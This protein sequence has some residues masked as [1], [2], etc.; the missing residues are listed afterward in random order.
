MS[1]EVNTTLQNRIAVVTGAG[2]GIGHAIAQALAARGA[3]LCLVG[4]DRAKLDATRD[5]LPQAPAA[6]VHVCD[7][8]EP[9]DISALASAIARAHARVD[10]LVHCAATI[11]MGPIESAP[12]ADFDRQF[13][14]NLRAP[15]LLTQLLL[16]LVK[17]ASGQIAFINSSVAL[18]GKEGVGAYCATKHGLKGLADT[19]R[20]EVN[21]H[22]IR[23]LSVYAGNTD[24]PMQREIHKHIGK[25][26]DPLT[27][28]Q[29]GDIASML[30]SALV[31]PRSAEITD[32]HI[33]PMQGSK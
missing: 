4:R 33:R 17:K 16:P 26:Y 12:V 21:A 19:L 25:A 29:P 13:Q 6:S 22:G 14:T 23:V 15:Y 9:N 30:V 27:L 20:L 2:S 3:I 24:T 7:L 5:T 31:L 10:I 28:L 18:R 8:V 1:P 32:L 11:A